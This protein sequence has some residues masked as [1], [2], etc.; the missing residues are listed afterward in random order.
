MPDS[1]PP[2]R[3]IDPTITLGAALQIGVLIVGFIGYQLQSSGKVDQTAKEVADLKQAVAAQTVS[4]RADLA[5]QNTSTRDLVR[6]S[7]GRVE[8]AV[9]GLQGQ[10]RDVPTLTERQRSTEEAIK[11]IEDRD[12]QMSRYLDERRAQ[13]D[14]RF[15]VLEQ[16][17]IESTSDRREL[18]SAIEAIQRASQVNLPGARGVRP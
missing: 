11:R 9:N 2:K 18:R 10:M 1:P 3:L 6:E 16:R 13:L 15:Q 8:A 17:A 4:A 12:I 14:Q 7:V 5:Q